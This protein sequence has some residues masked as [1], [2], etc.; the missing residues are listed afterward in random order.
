[1]PRYEIRTYEITRVKARGI[2]A[3]SSADAMGEF[4]GEVNRLLAGG[5]A[6][7]D[8]NGPRF[9]VEIIDENGRTVGSVSIP[10]NPP[11]SP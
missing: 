7:H 3:E 8:R 9:L 5:Y 4:A 6:K 2:E 10:G 1:M 11:E